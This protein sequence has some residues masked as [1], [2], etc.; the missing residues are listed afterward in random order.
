V[1]DDVTPLAGKREKERDRSV[2]RTG[3]RLH[4]A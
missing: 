4:D 3:H 2:R 1:A